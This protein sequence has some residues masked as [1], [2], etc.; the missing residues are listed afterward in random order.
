MTQCAVCF[1]SLFYSFFPGHVSMWSQAFIYS[2]WGHLAEKRVEGKE[3]SDF[4][5]F[6]KLPNGKC[7]VNTQSL[8]N[9]D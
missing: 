2:E 7:Y 4:V 6:V 9:F 3:P 1:F 8:P 5:G